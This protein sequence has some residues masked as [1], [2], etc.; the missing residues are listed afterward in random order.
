MDKLQFEA[1]NKRGTNTAR[2]SLKSNS[3]IKLFFANRYSITDYKKSKERGDDM[4]D[5]AVVGVKIS[6][7]EDI[8]T[9]D[10]M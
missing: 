5:F 7:S 8:N 3:S 6:I 9:A 4:Q 10:F 2:G 1:Y